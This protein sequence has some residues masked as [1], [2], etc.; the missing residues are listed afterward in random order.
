M[1]KICICGALRLHDLPRAGQ[2]I[3][4]RIVAEALESKYGPIYKI[5]TMGH[6]NRIR[7][8]FQ[9]LWAIMACHNII[10]LPAS[11]GIKIFAPLL[12]WMNI[13]FHR[14]LHYV[15]IGG[16]LQDFLLGHIH[17]MRALQKFTGIYV[18]TS[19]MLNALQNMGY[20]NVFLMPNCKKLS[21]ISPKNLTQEYSE[22]Y[23]LVT[24]SR[25]TE[26]KG[27]GTAIDVV[28]SINAKYGRELY[29]LDIYGPVDTKKSGWFVNEQRRFT[30][31]IQ[32]KGNRA[33]SDSVDILSK[34]FALLFPT[35]YY[36]EGIP[37]TIIDAYAAGIPV[38]CSRWKSCTDIVEDTVT[39]YVYE[40]GN[41]DA[42]KNIL[43]DIAHNPDKILNLKKNCLKRAHDFLPE[44]ALSP[45][46]NKIM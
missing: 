5:D 20:S 28:K 25:V 2:D 10:I 18:E 19:M 7:L 42:F 29:T 9:L 40:F 41:D 43:Y 6:F 15:V 45:L 1:K 8:V 21:I 31:A 39:G 16:W 13:L 14:K 34:Y 3:K 26:M 36:T 12:R 4:T 24:F 11:N 37:G 46:F 17:T 23:K 35:K 27:I 22:P 30:P 38:I 44:K 32:Y 33:F